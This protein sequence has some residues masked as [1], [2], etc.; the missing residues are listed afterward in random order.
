MLVAVRGRNCQNRPVLTVGVVALG[1]TD[2]QRAATFWCQGSGNALGGPHTVPH[3]KD[4]RVV[5]PRL[6]DHARGHALVE[7]DDGV[8]YLLHGGPCGPTPPHDLVHFITEQQLGIADGIWGAI[9]SGVVFRSMVHVSG[10]RPPHAA[11]RSARLLRDFRGPGLRAELM[12][13]VVEKIATLGALT[14]PEVRRI[15]ASH[16]SVLE[17]PEIDPAAIAAAA[18]TLRA[19]ARRWSRLPVG[20]QLTYD[21]PTASSPR[22]RPGR[23][24]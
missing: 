22:R 19:E 5:F 4:M 10:R 21:W 14:L 1:V 16:L 23:A 24:H 7:R 12:G 3:S 11:E 2:V 20:A 13:G 6:P 18:D 9:A 17:E 8:I 15:A